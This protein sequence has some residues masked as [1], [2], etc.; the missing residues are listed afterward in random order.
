M[1]PKKRHYLR[2]SVSKGKSTGTSTRTFQK[3]V[4][5]EDHS[6]QPRSLSSNCIIVTHHFSF[7]M[8]GTCMNS[9]NQGRKRQ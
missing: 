3:E 5:I 1:D 9:N 4:A 6:T 7:W 2:A 8:D